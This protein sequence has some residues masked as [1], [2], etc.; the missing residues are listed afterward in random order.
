MYNKKDLTSIVMLPVPSFKKVNKQTFENSVINTII[1]C[2]VLKRFAKTTNNN[3][4]QDTHGFV[5]AYL[6]SK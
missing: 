5:T 3:F 6:T 4:F 1:A 2:T